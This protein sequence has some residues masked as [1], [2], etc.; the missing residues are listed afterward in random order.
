MLLDKIFNWL[1]TVVVKTNNNR[2]DAIMAPLTKIKEQLIEYGN[3]LDEQ[4]E[5]NEK[6]IGRAT[7]NLASI[8]VNKDLA[9]N[10]STRINNLLGD[11]D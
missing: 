7:I 11:D 10:D 9:L 5:R 6:E 1:D 4:K 2:L 3:A 8:K